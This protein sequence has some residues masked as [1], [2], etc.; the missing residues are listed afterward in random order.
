MSCYVIQLPNSL[1][2]P[3]PLGDMENTGQYTGIKNDGV[4]C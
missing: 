2:R 4:S 3:G 1:S